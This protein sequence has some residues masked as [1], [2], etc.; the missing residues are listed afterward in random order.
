MR[1]KLVQMLDLVKYGDRYVYWDISE[2]LQQTR[3]ET[4]QMEIT[5]LLVKEG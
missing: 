4:L 1:G 2:E 3:K 5:G